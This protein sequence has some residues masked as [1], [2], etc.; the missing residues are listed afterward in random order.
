VGQ[1]ADTA[2][3]W[4]FVNHL[5]CN[6]EQLGSISTD[7]CGV[8]LGQTAGL[9]TDGTEQDGGAARLTSLREQRSSKSPR[10]IVKK[11]RAD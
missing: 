2:G 9:R 7:C 3:K 4:A 8:E 5:G 1:S 6:A 11:I 10:V